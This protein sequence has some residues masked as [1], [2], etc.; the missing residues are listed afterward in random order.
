[1]TISLALAV[2][3]FALSTL[4]SVAS[5]AFMLGSFSEHKKSTEQRLTALE[6]ADGHSITREE[7]HAEF[8]AVRAEIA[9]V[10]ANTSNTSQRIS[11]LWHMIQ[12]NYAK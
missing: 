3:A 1:M 9:T 5:L 11:E 2:A 4:T 7:M 6:K 10:N 8:R 12:E